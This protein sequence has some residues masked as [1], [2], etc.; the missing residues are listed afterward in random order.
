[1]SELLYFAVWSKQ[2]GYALD[3]YPSEIERYRRD[4]KKHGDKFSGPYLTK[5]EALEI[6]RK[7]LMAQYQ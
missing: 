6:V 1:M 3:C 7:E 4:L 2:L 5:Q